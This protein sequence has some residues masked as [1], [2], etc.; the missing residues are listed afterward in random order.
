MI[1]KYNTLGNG[2]N[3]IVTESQS[4]VSWGGNVREDLA[5]AQGNFLGW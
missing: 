1:S 2:N 5:G 3:S 4:V